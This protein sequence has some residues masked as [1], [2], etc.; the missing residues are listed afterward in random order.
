MAKKGTPRKRRTREHVLADLSIHHVE[1]YVLR[2]GFT[3]ERVAHDYG[4]DLLLF[5]YND[6]GEIENGEIRFQVKATESPRILPD[7][8]AI[9]FRLEQKDVRFWLGELSPVILIVYDGN[10]DQAFWLYVQAYFAKRKAW[11]LGQTVTVHLPM[12]NRLSE[13][14]VKLFREFR[15]NVA[16]QIEGVRHEQ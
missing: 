2:C 10:K 5:T 8:K 14:A 7:K 15:D 6:L 1:G 11:A 13:D 3:L 12:A 16:G 4:V 9:A